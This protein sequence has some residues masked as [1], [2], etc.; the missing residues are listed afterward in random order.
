MKVLLISPKF[1]AIGQDSFISGYTIG[2]GILYIAAAAKDAGHEVVVELGDEENIINLIKKHS[3]DIVGITCLTVSYPTAKNMIN[4]VKKYNPN[5]LTII[6]GHH[7]TFM[8]K[9]I[10]SECNIDYILRGEGETAFPLLLKQIESGN[11]YPIIE[12]IAFRKDNKIFNENSFTLLENIDSLPKITL[13]L[14]PKE[15]KNF[16]PL[17]STSRGCPFRC[18]FCSISA[19]YNGKWRARKIENILDEIEMYALDTHIKNF[20]FNDDN[21]TVDTKRVREI[22]DG[23]KKRGL[24]NLKWS[25]ESRVDSICRDPGMVDKMTDAGCTVM[26]LGAESGVQEIINTYNKNITL[27]QVLKAVKIMNNSSIFHAWFMIIGSGDKYDRPKYIEK[28]IDFM[29]KV[30]FDILQISILTPFPG[31]ELFNKITSGNRLLHKNW[32]KYD[33]AH[34]VYRPLHL[35]PK[36]IEEY[37][38]KAYK[39]LYLSRGLDLLKIILKGFKSGWL[40]PSFLLKTTRYGIDVFLRKKNIYEVM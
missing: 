5:I 22:C 33:C 24:D 16:S 12:G 17:I 34:C 10:F 39:T 40:N 20:W 1:K 35:T 9:E 3:P 2:H 4:I 18:S 23:L 8:T 29:K 38:V 27:E 30:K 7:A 36:Q 31:T 28:N 6:G 11:K 15:I 13:D 21:L 14:I 19:F 32:K 37:F 26:A 25:C